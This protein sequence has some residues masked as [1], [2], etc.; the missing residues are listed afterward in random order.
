MRMIGQVVMVVLG[1][2]NNDGRPAMGL[3]T[4]GMHDI[5]FGIVNRSPSSVG[6]RGNSKRRSKT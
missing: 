3:V 1:R 5:R 6:T 2:V 4:I